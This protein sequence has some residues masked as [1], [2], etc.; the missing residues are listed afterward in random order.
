MIRMFTWKD[1]REWL[2]VDKLLTHQKSVQFAFLETVIMKISEFFPTLI[3]FMKT[4]HSNKL[5]KSRSCV[6][7]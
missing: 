7:A 2:L 1:R 4:G 5:V 6:L 3:E